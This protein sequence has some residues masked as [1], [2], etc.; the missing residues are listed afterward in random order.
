MTFVHAMTVPRGRLRNVGWMPEPTLTR[1]PIMQRLII[2]I[3]LA[4]STKALAQTSPSSAVPEVV[5]TSS[6]P[7]MDN[8]VSAFGIFSYWYAETGLGLGVRYQKTLVPT[9][10]LKLAN[11]HDDIGLEG[12]LDYYHYGFSTL[13]YN[14]TYNEFAL[15]VGGVWNFWFL[16]DK[17]AIYPKIDLGYRFGSWSTNTGITSPG[18]F[19][20][21]VVQGSAGVVYKISRVTLRAEVGSG[22]LRLGAGFAL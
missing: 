3:L 20:G 12:G 17:L 19:G 6:S 2:A 5:A 16:N 7:T 22:S 15:L 13:G 11:V 8:V 4:I 9:G 10:V 14:W 21:L 1:S 18:G